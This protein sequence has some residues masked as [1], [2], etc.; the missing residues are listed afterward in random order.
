MSILEAVDILESRQQVEALMDDFRLEIMSELRRPDSAVGLSRRLAIPRQRLNYHLRALESAGL[1]GLVEER[2]QRNCIERIMQTTAHSYV[3]SPA[4]LSSLAATA[5]RSQDHFSWTYLVSLAGRALRELG[6][7]RRRADEAGKKL[8]TFS[9]DTEIAF[10]SPKEFEAFVSELS[11]HMNR[12]TKKYHASSG[13][14]K[15][16][17]RVLIAAYPKPSK[18]V[19]EGPKS[20]QEEGL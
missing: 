11:E 17:F 2:R 7:V 6:L 12:L 3:I 10:K 16:G 13:T 14:G 5:Q 4:V 19:T 18:P 9:L 20:Q 8:A 1:V 15:R